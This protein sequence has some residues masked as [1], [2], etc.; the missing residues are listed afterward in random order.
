MTRRL[1]ISVTGVVLLAWLFASGLAAIA[2]Q[3]E[4]AE[5]FDGAVQETADRLL[6]L[7]MDDLSDRNGGEMREISQPTSGDEYLTYQVRNAEGHVIMHSHDVSEVPYSVPLKVGFADTQTHR[8]YTAATADGSLF[9]QVADAFENRREAV[10]EAG[11]ALLYPLIALVP[12]SI[13][14][15][16]FVVSRMLKPIG[17]LRDEILMKDSGNMAPV[18]DDRLPRE[19]E[20]IARSVNH[21]LERLRSALDAER[22]FASNSA[23]ELR[24]PI[25]GALAQAQRLQAEIPPEHRNR[26]DQIETSL[27]HLARLAEKLLQM[28]R[29]EA[30]IGVS[31]GPNDLMPILKLILQDFERLPAG[32]GRILLQDEAAQTIVH[33]INPDAFGIV[34]RNLIE[35]ALIHGPE[36][37]VVDVVIEND[38]E[39]RIINGGPVI[40]PQALAKLTTRFAR[41]ATSASGSGLGLSIVASLVPHM[42]GSLELL[43][44][45]GGRSD[46]FEARITLGT[47]AAAKA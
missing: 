14:V 17:G 27:S 43:S 2:M 42:G 19:L 46:G 22:E 23:H 20:P 28:S 8:I 37:G 35:N 45:A 31:D 39:I 9:I 5:I 26:V 3:Y 15:V 25:A 32:E 11:G 36:D 21:L 40:D 24:T 41:G 4:F 16:I 44:P 10:R 13:L 33:A 29:A 6:P 47:G 38:S 7:A 30:G 34:I 18:K 1:V 12:L